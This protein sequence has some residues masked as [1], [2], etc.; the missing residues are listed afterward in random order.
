[1]FILLQKILPQHLLSRLVGFVANS[2]NPFVR[3][4]FIH[5]AIGRYKI[6]LTDALEPNPDAYKSFN[7][8]FTRGLKPGSRPIMGTICSPADGAVSECGDICEGKLLQAK[9]IDYRLDE[10]LA[11]DDVSAYQEGS[12]STIYLSPRDYHRVHCPMQGELTSASYVPG[13]LFSVNQQTADAIPNLFARNERLVMEFNSEQG[14]FCVVMVGALIVA[15]IQSAWHDA[16]YPARQ[17]FI[18]PEAKGN[19]SAGAELGRFVMGS[20]AIVIS[21]K[22][23]KLKHV[24]GDAVVMGESLIEQNIA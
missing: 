18:D 7:D 24:A 14:P 15:G 23:L 9:G 13:D 22:R 16:P 5:W 8:F 19:F 11:S 10:L 17:L 4:T 12:F 3:R 20:T 1:M 21:S 2:Q 6:D